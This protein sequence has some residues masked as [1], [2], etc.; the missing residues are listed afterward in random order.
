MRIAVSGT[1]RT[2]KTSLVEALARVRPD[3]ELEPEPYEQLLESGEDF[4]DH[5]DPESFVV[6][7]EHLV[8]RLSRRTAY[9]RVI[10]DRSPFDFLAYVAASEARRLDSQPVGSDLVELAAR[11]LDHLDLVVWLPLHAEGEA[12]VSRSLRRRVDSHL[13][14]IIGADAFGLLSGREGPRI[15]ELRGSTSHRLAGLTGWL[16][17]SE[18]ER[19]RGTIEIEEGSLWK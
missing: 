8:T 16:D 13:A 7:L 11:G 14:E 10:F 1:H 9:D 15:L 19:C 2:G 17:R 6:Q 4:L 5:Y 12:R 3:F 18:P